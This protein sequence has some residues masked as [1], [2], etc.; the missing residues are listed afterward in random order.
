MRKTLGILGLT[1]LCVALLDLGVATFLGWAEP[2]GRF[3]SLVQYFEYGRSTPGKLAR[4]E[5]GTDAMAGL[6]GVAWRP[7][8]VTESTAAFAAEPDQTR[9]V[10]RGY[11]MSF[12]A[13]ILELAGEMR[14]GLR[15]DMHAGPQAP[16]NF[17]YALFEDDRPNRRPGDIAVLG[18]LS[19]SVPGMAALSNQTWAF[20][21]PAP[22]TYPIY[23]PDGEGLR[24]MDPVIE[25][26]AAHRALA[27]DP[28][29]AA[30]W[31]EQLA[32]E[33][34][35]H[36]PVTYGARLFDRSP[37]CRLIRR[38]L[39]IS[40]IQRV[41]ERVRDGDIY[42]VA[43]VL[44]RMVAAFARAA[45]ADGQRPVVAL[46]QS[47]DPSDIDLLATLAPILEREGIPYLATAEHFDPRDPSGF[48]P[49]GH[50]VPE[51]DTRFARAFLRL[52]E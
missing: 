10:I 31:A 6:Y 45:R 36:G 35:F 39:A 34:V 16:P 48:A 21:Q 26:E 15:L 22:F 29:L 38:S 37:L 2:R 51:I 8:I 23:L 30:T 5:A 42:P 7:A 41:E 40:S 33:D 28:A 12:V 4:W 3:P 20:E 47:R 46:I 52:I 18:V 44:G 50:Y 43:D 32:R 19:S 27:R 1:C 17:V 9:P 24:R 25:T 13:N 11:G 14:P 49:D